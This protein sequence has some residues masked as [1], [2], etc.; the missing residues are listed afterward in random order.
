[1]V[2]NCIAMP[3]GI[4]AITITYGDTDLNLFVPLDSELNNCWDFTVRSGSHG[5]PL[6]VL[7]R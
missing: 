3:R 5:N 1:M 4:D 2:I 7:A 6:R